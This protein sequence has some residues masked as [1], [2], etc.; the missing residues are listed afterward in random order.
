MILKLASN[1]INTSNG[2]TLFFAIIL[3][4]S[5]LY[6]E[7]FQ[8]P[9]KDNQEFHKNLFLF[10]ED[11]I[12]N[13]D[14]V[15]IHNRL[16]DFVIKRKPGSFA[17]IWE[18]SE[19]R[20]LPASQPVV[21]RILRTLRGIRIRKFYPKGS[22][23]LANFSLDA[24]RMYFELFNKDG[25]KVKIYFGLVNP[26]DNSTY[27]MTSDKDSIYHI[28]SLN[29][30]VEKLGLSD[31]VDSHIFSFSKKQLTSIKIFRGSNTQVNPLN[32]QLSVLHGPKGYKN[33]SG[34]LLEPNKVEKYLSELLALKSI[35]ILDKITEKL[36]NK[37]DSILS[38]PFYTVQVKTTS[39]ED[40][41]YTISTV[42]SNLPD[43]K[44]DKKQTFIIKAS[45]RKYP[46]IL[47]RTN[48]KLFGMKSSA[49]KELPFKK[50]FY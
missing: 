10:Q 29:T 9:T 43:L 5:G 15:L 1:R 19:P 28:D 3:A 48:F 42:V 30:S 6:S 46:T 27:L 37:L 14:Q 21:N 44:I 2:L 39:G 31:F 16:G 25:P 8:A 26:I 23:N 4:F 50:L 11:D 18:L 33:K 35:Y 12:A 38:K 13:I 22:I 45:N 40:I 49:L 24:P 20:Q 41:T 32:P 34:L 7:F 17:N 36:A 47:D